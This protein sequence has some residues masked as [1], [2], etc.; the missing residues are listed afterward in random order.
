MIVNKFD[1]QELVMFE[2]RLRSGSCVA[3]TTTPDHSLIRL[4]YSSHYSIIHHL[5]A[6]MSY[7]G[8]W[9]ARY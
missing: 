5:M 4:D 6:V 3:E 1:G 7:A 8:S 9:N 2:V